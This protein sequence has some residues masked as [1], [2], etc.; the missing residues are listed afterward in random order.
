MIILALLHVKRKIADD[1]HSPK[2]SFKYLLHN[3]CLAVILAKEF[4]A[5]RQACDLWGKSVQIGEDCR[6]PRAD[7]HTLE[8]RHEISRPQAMMLGRTCSIYSQLCLFRALWGIAS[9]RSKIIKLDLIAPSSW[10][11]AFIFLPLLG[12]CI[13]HHGLSSTQLKQLKLSEFDRHKFCMHSLLRSLFFWCELWG[14][15]DASN[16]FLNARVSSEKSLHLN[17]MIIFTIFHCHY[18]CP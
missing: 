14:K 13:G 12:L 4:L 2:T 6:L 7:L 15:S 18:Q 17:F 11:F 3:S 5:L 9:F 8:V 16:A 1:Y 10:H